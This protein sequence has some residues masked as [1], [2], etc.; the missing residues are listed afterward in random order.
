[1]TTGGLP[2]ELEA[3]FEASVQALARGESEPFPERLGDRYEA[4]RAGSLERRQ[5]G[6]HYTPDTLTGPVVSATL[7]SL[8]RGRSKDEILALTVVDPAMGAGAFLAASCRFLAERLIE[9]DES[10]SC[11]AARELVARNCLYG[12]DLDPVAVVL[13]QRVLWL[14]VGNP[15]LSLDF[16]SKQLLCG[17]ALV[18]EGSGPEACQDYPSAP[19]HWHRSFPAVFAQGGFRALI[20]NPPFRNA[21]EH[22]MA[23]DREQ[24][25][26]WRARWPDFSA[27]AADRSLL[28]WAR[29]VRELLAPGGRYGMISPTALLSDGGRWQAWMFEHW[30]PD[31]L[32]LE[33]VD[34]FAGAR[35]RTTAIIGGSGHCDAV[36]V[37][38][39]EF[40]HSGAPFDRSWPEQAPRWYAM[41]RPE[42][43]VLASSKC[44]PLSSW[45]RVRAGCATGVAYALRDHVQDSQDGPGPRLVTT[46]ALDRYRLRWGRTQRF[47]GGDY[48]YPRW[49]SVETHVSSLSRA[50]DAQAGPKLLGGGLTRVLEAW[51]DAKGDA[52]GIVSTWVIQPIGPEPDWLA[53]LLVVLNSPTATR[54]YRQTH[55]GASMSGRQVTI[56]KRALLDLFSFRV[57]CGGLRAQGCVRGPS[58][59][60]CRAR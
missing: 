33:P 49:P 28:F 3:V 12:V 22:R 36:Q 18:G 37:R 43:V 53:A 11:S 16:M 35:V 54:L 59:G 41:T 15:G 45:F 6:A 25:D 56:K 10:L 44:L 17:D 60:S 24:K 13:A 29:G 1:M 34:R 51:L 42:P 31:H 23:A 26:W 30:R 47:L 50:R 46:G 48:R 4:L 8:V 40:G 14:V 21:V 27:G 52:A 19:F 5:G 55:G 2:V 9:Q 20:G 7:S 38:D 32:W 39:R 58:G 57:A